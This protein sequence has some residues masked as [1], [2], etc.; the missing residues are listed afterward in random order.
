MGQPTGI[1]ERVTGAV[2]WNSVLTPVKTLL[3]FAFSFTVVRVLSQNDYAAFASVIALLT[4]VGLWSDLGIE[5][6]IDRFFPEVE[7]RFGRVGVLQFGGG[8]LAFKLVLLA[9]VIVILFLFSNAVSAYFQFGTNGQTYLVIAACLLFMGILSDFIY[10]FLVANFHLRATNTMDVLFAAAQPVLLVLFV[11][12]GWGVVGVL[13]ARLVSTI[14]Y[15]AMGLVFARNAWNALLRVPAL[16]GNW[17]DLLRRYV[18]LSGLSYVTNLIGFFSDISFV[19]FVLTFYHDEVGIA[20]FAVAFSRVVSPICQL[21]MAPT[22]GFTVPMFARLYVKK[23]FAK[24]QEAYGS[25]SRL[26]ILLLVPSGIGLALL[27]PNLIRLLF[28]ARYE[29]AASISAVLIVGLFGEGL[30]S[31]GVQVLFALEEIRHSLISR[32]I[33]LLAIPILFAAVPTLGGLG[34]ALAIGLARLAARVYTTAVVRRK[35]GLEFPL[36]FFGRVLLASGVMALA[37]LVPLGIDRPRDPVEAA[38]RTV[39]ALIVGSVVFLIAFKKLGSIE[40]SDRERLATMRIPFRRLILNW[41]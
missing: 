37:T 6:T 23:E 28:Q 20:L 19:V 18:R 33:S 31:T 40:E 30:L 12:F 24:I 22:V 13:L 41:L 4:S 32:L 10:Q 36:P 11:F 9:V 26:L 15:V 38:I 39:L 7:Q 2:F 3:S 8:L 34:A 21:L 16:E 29:P 17:G 25:L 5:S 35:I 1:G 27:A 14:L